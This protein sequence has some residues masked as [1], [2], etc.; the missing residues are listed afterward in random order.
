VH[1]Q[2]V[3]EGAPDRMTVQL[4]SRRQGLQPGTKTQASDKDDGISVMQ[5]YRANC[6][7]PDVTDGSGTA[8]RDEVCCDTIPA[9]GLESEL[10][11]KSLSA[12]PPT[13][14]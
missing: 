2:D 6:H 12:R 11:G 7:S 3:R 9:R 5:S 1:R 10:Q 4:E 14:Y 8:Q 13:E